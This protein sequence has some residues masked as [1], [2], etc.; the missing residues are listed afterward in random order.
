[1]TISSKIREQVRQRADFSCE[2]CGV[3]ETDTGGELTI[4]HF[5]PRSKGGSDDLSNIL[6]CCNR[7]NQYKADYYSASSNVPALWNPRQ[8]SV[9]THL[10]MLADGQLYPITEIGRF[11]LE[12]L[13]LNR[14]PLVAYRL[15]KQ[16]QSERLRLLARLQEVLALLEQ[17]R[18]QQA[19][20]LEE[21]Q[22][23]LKEQRTIL[24]L[25]LDVQDQI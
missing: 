2:Y 8:E 12:R 11:T 23:L 5:H 24:K 21:H 15:Q 10:L 7:C 4:D 22:I 9:T 17:L 13:R 20:L 18:Q 25:L 1:M 19:A 6:Y 16:S 3:A 14:S